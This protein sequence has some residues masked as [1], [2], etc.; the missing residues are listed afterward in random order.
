[1]PEVGLI[2]LVTTKQNRRWIRRV[3]RRISGT[4]EKQW[5]SKKVSSQKS[6]DLLESNIFTFPRHQQK[7]IKKLKKLLE[8]KYWTTG[9]FI[10]IPDKQTNKATEAG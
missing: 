2:R 9:T 4:V 6:R 5:R 7:I 3:S 8:N 1:M 10:A